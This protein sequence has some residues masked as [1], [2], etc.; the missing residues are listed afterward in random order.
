MTIFNM[1]AREIS[2]TVAHHAQVRIM[3]T[4]DS[5]IALELKN[6]LERSGLY[7]DRLMAMQKNDPG[8]WSRLT[9][10][11]T[12]RFFA[13]WFRNTR[14]RIGFA[15]QAEP[16]LLCPS[17]KRWSSSLLICWTTITEKI[18]CVSVLEHRRPELL[19]IAWPSYIC[20]NSSILPK[21]SSFSAEMIL[22]L[23]S[24]A[25]N[26]SNF[27]FYSSSNS[28]F[29]VYILSLDQTYTSIYVYIMFCIKACLLLDVAQLI[30]H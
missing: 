12:Q 26:S 17:A 6:V 24:M 2:D 4:Q 21:I 30:R 15:S 3:P 9:G 23:S 27:T 20:A 10:K 11:F 8:I 28:G 7:Q 5:K 14:L 19:D 16:N 18:G 1:A 22:L 13:E 25:L 29:Y